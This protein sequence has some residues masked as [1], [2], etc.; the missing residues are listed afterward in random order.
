MNGISEDMNIDNPPEV[1]D[2]CKV[3]AHRS[4]S[5]C[6][7]IH[8]AEPCAAAIPGIPASDVLT[9]ADRYK[10]LFVAVQTAR[11]FADS[12]TF[13]D[14]APKFNPETILARYRCAHDLPEFSLKA[15]VDAHF[16]LP[17]VYDSRYVADAS[18]NIVAHIDSLWNVL[19]RKPE[20]HPE[21][22]SQIALPAQYVVPGGRFG[23][24][25]YWDS[26]FIMLG[27]TVSGRHD[28]L[29]NIA[30]NFAYLIDTYGHVP[31]GNRTYY[32]SRSQPP[33]FALMVELLQHE[34]VKSA[35]H[36]LPQL[37][38]EYGFWMAGVETLVPGQAAQHVVMLPDGEILNRYWDKRDTPREEAYAEDVET[39]KDSSR[40][41]RDVY[42]DLRSAAASGWD[43][44]SRW[45]EDPCRLGSIRTTS[46]LPVD[47][48]AL[49]Y[50]LE[51]LIAELA[52]Q[53]GQA[54]LANEFAEYA[55]RRREAINRI[56]WDQASG[57]Y[58]DYD[59]CHAEKRPLNAAT[60]APLFVR[61]A[62]R[63]QAAAVAKATAAHLLVN[64]GVCSTLVR[65]GQQ[66]DRPNGWA[67]IQWIAVQ[68]LYFYE[69]KHLAETIS[70]RW[71]DVV[72]DLYKQQSKL[73]E[74]YDLSHAGNAQGG[75]GGEYPLQDGFGWTNGVT[76]KLLAM[77]GQHKTN[78]ASAQRSSQ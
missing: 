50:K 14:C 30:D 9:P 64:G 19:T 23:E 7:T 42:R 73:V 27:L 70:G 55:T 2:Q 28:L 41:A 71:L 20:H 11:I 66:W 58:R 67:P 46:I 36:Y 77:F 76:R 54:T 39:A 29:R 35:A 56:M 47:L 24:I 32:L 75:Y 10:E 69:E 45:L 16:S 72:G 61:M 40:D 38:R 62:N 59:W 63:E 60:L 37:C 4:V 43:F 78:L 15:F 18:Q 33:V 26:Y 65:T 6:L 3:G 21:Y 44:S 31:N 51:T 17:K 74:K 68:G 49:L 8:Y 34:N 52:E 22:S 12:K 25:Y 53:S 57:T 1:Q 5:C 48:N 13:V